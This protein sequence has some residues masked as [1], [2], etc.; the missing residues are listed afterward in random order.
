MPRVST[1][2]K[3]RQLPTLLQMWKIGI[4]GKRLST[5]GKR[6]RVTPGGRGESHN[7]V[8]SHDTNVQYRYID[9]DVYQVADRR[10][11]KLDEKSCLVM[12]QIEGVETHSLLETQVPMYPFTR[13]V[14]KLI[15]SS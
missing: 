4:F 5:N 12:C 10:V 15:P 7:D 13:E 11:L 8:R 3:G 6:P 2:R 1:G 9:G 14:A